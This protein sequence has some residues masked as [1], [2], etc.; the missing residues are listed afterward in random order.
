M[1]FKYWHKFISTSTRLASTK[2]GSVVSETWQCG[3]WGATSKN[4][5]ETFDQ[6][7]T[8]CHATIYMQNTYIP[9]NKQCDHDKEL[10]RKNTLAWPFNHVVTWGDVTNEKWHID[11]IVP[12]VK[13]TEPTD[14][15]DLLINWL[16]V[17]TQQLKSN[18]SLPLRGL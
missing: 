4:V 8:C 15:C 9:Q 17:I 14:S 2:L 10:L 16:L 1:F 13:G 11:K 7:V 6:V 3:R 12:Y 5:T 18:I